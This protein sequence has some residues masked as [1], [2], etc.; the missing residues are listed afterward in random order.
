M[1]R[2]TL[3]LLCDAG[4]EEYASLEAKELLKRTA[5]I[6]NSYIIVP[7]CSA[8]D[9]ALLCYR[10]QLAGRVLVLI[11][12][13]RI[14]GPEDVRTEEFLDF[15]YSPFLKEGSSFRAEC[16]R[17]G[18]HGFQ[19]PEIA[20]LLGE[21][22]HERRGFSVELKKP[23]MT[24]YCRVKDDGYVLGIDLA[25]R[26]LGKRDY[27]VFHTRQSMRGTIMYAAVR[28]AAYTGAEIMADPSV[29]DGTIPIEAAL[30]ATRRSPQRFRR[31]FAFLHMPMFGETDWGSFFSELD[32]ASSAPPRILGF[33]P[34]LRTLKMARQN[35]KLAG[36]EDSMA[37]TRCDLS[38]LDTK[39]EKGSVDIFVTVPP[40]S[41]KNTSLKD[42]EKLQDD[43]FTQ[44]D[45]ALKND[46]VVLLVA[47]KRAEF[48]NPA[49]R[50][51][52]RLAE[53]KRVRMGGKEL[54][55]LKFRRG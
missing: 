3:A 50:H 41:G 45:Y 28:A 5:V 19:S 40:S 42:V 35:A 10:S 22:L 52:F 12:E 27:K 14:T 53:E 33:S 39:L 20:A 24:V 17:S 29:I 38:W 48:L 30:Y 6:R 11:K 16:E 44:A 46:G 1:E 15:D 23:G 31:E 37:L 2:F 26:D 54:L 47:E 9:A 36:V 51:G 34:L 8:R 18:E 7:D 21:A 32:N 25:G 4:C 49:E 13:G 43:L 55:F